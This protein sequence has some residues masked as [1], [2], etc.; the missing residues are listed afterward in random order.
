MTQFGIA[1]SVSSHTHNAFAQTS[2]S[3]QPSYT[4]YQNSNVGYSVE[5][6]SNWT[7][8]E[9]TQ[10][11]RTSTSF[12]P[13]QHSATVVQL[14]YDKNTNYLGTD[15]QKLEHLPQI[16]STICS[17]AT[18]AAN[19]LS[20]SG[21]QYKTGMAQYHN[22]P[23][24]FMESSMIE[25]FS[26]G[27]SREQ[28][29]A[30]LFVIVQ[31]SDYGIL[32][33][34]PKVE[35]DSYHTQINHF[36]TSL[37]I[38]SIT[39]NTPT[40]QTTTN[41]IP[42]WI[43]N[44]AKWW[45]QGQVGDSDFIQGVQYLIK[46]GI[47]VVPTTQVSSQSPQTIPSWVKNTAKWWSQGQVTD[48]DFI[49]GIQ[50]LVQNGF[51]TIQTETQQA[52]TGILTGATFYNGTN[53]SSQTVTYTD[54]DGVTLSVN[55]IPG[56]VLLYVTPSS[57]QDVISQAVTS[58]GG[59]ILSGAPVA[60]F[61]LVQ[62]NDVK[63]F[64][65]NVLQ[66]PFVIDA[67]P[68]LVLSNSQFSSTSTPIQIIN[69][70]TGPVTDPDPTAHVILAVIDNFAGCGVL[71]TLPHGCKI[72]SEIQ[73]KNNKI[74]ILAIQT[75]N[76]DS[77]SSEY[78]IQMNVLRAIAVAQENN[79][80][81]VISQS[82]MPPLID[83][84]GNP[85]PNGMEN[86]YNSI[87]SK[88]KLL[89]NLEWVQKNNVLY[90]QSAGNDGQDVSPVMDKLA[91]QSQGSN[92]Y[93]SMYN[94]VGQLDPT[95]QQPMSYGG[96]SK[97]GSNYGKGITY[98][99]SVSSD[100]KYGTSCTT[101]NLAAGAAAIWNDNPNLPSTTIHNAIQD[102]AVQKNGNPV[103]SPQDAYNLANK[104]LPE[105][106]NIAYGT[107]P[108][109]GTTQNNNPPLSYA[110]TPQEAACQAKF[111]TQY[112]YSTTS[113]GC[114]L[115]YSLPTTPVGAGVNL[116]GNWEGTTTGTV[117]CTNPDQSDPSEN[118][119]C[120]FQGHIYLQLSQSGNNLQGS[121][122]VNGLATS[123]DNCDQVPDSLGGQLGGTIFGSGFSGDVE[124][125]RVNGQFTSDLIKGTFSGEV[126][127]LTIRGQFTGYRTG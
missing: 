38:Y 110:N 20:C 126:G 22:V 31:N 49:Q 25:T 18:I 118:V 45:S 44:T 32:V 127:D 116:S 23:A 86:Y 99:D 78:E 80:K 89:G 12:L 64:I 76:D 111:G 104:C 48:S 40:A 63:N 114:V 93:K 115:G 24:Y 79:Q 112:H 60:G 21:F 109:G 50:Y 28:D 56:Q 120:D 10:G 119:N 124:G 58:N 125:L 108:S 68:N 51:I 11:G 69:Y 54:K 42:S 65:S 70:K 27:S 37:N 61:Y 2:S 122:T 13:Y 57:S 87:D 88:L 8:L 16:I 113:N 92:I 47:I 52:S 98:D 106:N 103:F 94:L 34:C 46:Q 30:Q 43:K 35:C 15:Q 84:K 33:S 4:P 59:T 107:T 17:G 121:V 53:P 97:A 90:Y 41:N 81:I 72:L 14:F 1:G 105:C 77:G 55:A 39:T 67:H 62:V 91:T 95:T 73:S 6:P 5:Y 71:K 102:S 7:Y 101:P 117:V 100:C 9:Q 3:N 82:S 19:G 83:D 29:M 26:D 66:K 85:I 36:L 75:G 74:P 123:G 96:V